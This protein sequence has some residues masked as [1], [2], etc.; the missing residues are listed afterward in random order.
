MTYLNRDTTNLAEKNNRRILETVFA[1]LFPLDIDPRSRPFAK[2]PPVSSPRRPA[3]E[4]GELAL[5]HG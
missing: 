4:H 2:L 5:R 1:R 3:R